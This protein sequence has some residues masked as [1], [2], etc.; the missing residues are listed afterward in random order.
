MTDRLDELSR[1]AV[2][3]LEALGGVADFYKDIGAC[4]PA[5][6]HL[7]DPRLPEADYRG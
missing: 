4:L 3:K 5:A 2:A 1:Q 7:V 6:G